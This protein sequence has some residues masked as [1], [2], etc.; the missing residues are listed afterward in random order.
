M[1]AQL[2]MLL[3]V[4]HYC[5]LVRL[6]EIPPYSSFLLNGIRRFCPPYV[7]SKCSQ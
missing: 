2:L 6:L 1:E 4:L 5:L 3:S 7:Y